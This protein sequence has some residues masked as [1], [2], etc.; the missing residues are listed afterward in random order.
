MMHPEEAGLGVRALRSRNTGRNEVQEF[1]EIMRKSLDYLRL[2]NE[3]L[4]E[5]IRSL[6]GRGGRE[7][8]G[9]FFFK[10]RFIYVF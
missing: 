7:T 3:G 2:K 1:V 5:F 6:G 10:K 4:H 9:I 8:V